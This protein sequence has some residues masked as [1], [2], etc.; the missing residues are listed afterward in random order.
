[1]YGDELEEAPPE[2]QARAVAQPGELWLL[3]PHRVLCADARDPASYAK[4]L[5]GERVPMVFTDPPYNVRINGHVCGLGQDQASRVRHGLGRDVRDEFIAFLHS[6]SATWQLSRRMAPSTS[7]SWT[8][9]HAYELLAGRPR[10]YAELK[11]I[12]VWAKS[13]GWHGQ[14]LPLTARAGVCLEAWHGRRTSTPS[15]S[16]RP[17]ATGPMSG[18]MPGS[19]RSGA[20]VPRSSGRIRR[21][22]RW[23]W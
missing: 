2:P 11:N 20:V 21:S 6:C 10:V 9:A 3:G 16:A 8:G 15:S 18:S 1:M 4:L 13:N 23:P 12:C 17:A 14:L 5:G 19:T 22:S 7:C